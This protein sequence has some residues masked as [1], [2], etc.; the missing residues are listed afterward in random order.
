[1]VRIN[2]MKRNPE[3]FKLSDHGFCHVEWLQRDNPGAEFQQQLLDFMKIYILPLSVVNLN[4]YLQNKN[5]E[6]SI[7]S[8]IQAGGDPNIMVQSTTVWGTD[9]WGLSGD[10][11][12]LVGLT[13][14]PLLIY[15]IEY[16]AS[17][18]KKD[19]KGITVYPPEPVPGIEDEE[20][21]EGL[22]SIL[23]REGGD[24]NVTNI[25]SPDTQ[26][27]LSPGPMFKAGD[28]IEFQVR[29]CG[30]LSSMEYTL[31]E[32]HEAGAPVLINIPGYQKSAIR[33]ALE[34]GLYDIVEEFLKYNPIVELQDLQFLRG[35][36]EGANQKHLILDGAFKA[37]LEERKYLV[38]QLEDKPEGEKGAL[39]DA[40]VEH[41]FKLHQLGK[42]KVEELELIK[43]IVRIMKI[44]KPVEMDRGKNKGLYET[45]KKEM[46]NDYTDDILIKHAITLLLFKIFGESIEI[47]NITKGDPVFPTVFKF[48]TYVC[49]VTVEGTPVIVQ[50]T[51]VNHQFRSQKEKERQANTDQPFPKLHTDYNEAQCIYYEERRACIINLWL[52]LTEDPLYSHSL[53]LMN[54]LTPGESISSLADTADHK[55]PVPEDMDN[56]YT[57]DG[58]EYGQGYFFQST[59]VPHSSLTYTT[60]SLKVF[61]DNSPD[62]QAGAKPDDKTE[63]EWDEEIETVLEDL[64]RYLAVDVSNAKQIQTKWRE[65][66]A[67]K[68]EKAAITI[69]KMERGR[70]AR[71]EGGMDPNINLLR[72]S[73]E[74][75]FSV[76]IMDPELHNKYL[77]L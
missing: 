50:I 52:N 61:S 55:V 2:D 47:D 29:W 62:L 14:I 37:Y 68:E 28:T 64:Y 32:Y 34:L 77:G 3:N 1:L 12:E 9:T 49:T 18:R 69:Q 53:M 43:E 31:P 35:Q 21:L 17:S 42:K 6:Q 44:M 71:Q 72:E 24:V 41:D 76:Q 13:S 65:Y 66:V 16:I 10:Y 20:T 67:K 51:Q 46:A 22:V 73:F 48:T 75:R 74:I 36:G 23:L 38:K 63:D 8:H 57:Y 60:D 33:I 11:K 45:K 25:D 19:E 39:R 54:K 30:L 70:Q 5:F 26:Y 27:L 40:L 56:F 15:C 59:L 4:R 58:L 7:I